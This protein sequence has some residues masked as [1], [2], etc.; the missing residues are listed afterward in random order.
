MEQQSESGGESEQTLKKIEIG[1]DEA[2][3][4][5]VMGSMFV[6]G[7]LGFDRLA[8]IGV[9]DS[10]KLNSARRSHLARIIEQQTTAYVA[11]ISASQIDEERRRGRSMNDITLD[12]ASDVVC[13]FIRIT[14]LPLR[15]FVDAA[16]VKPAR[17][18]ER[19]R[20]CCSLRCESAPEIISEWKADEKYPVVS[21]AS[22]IAK[23]HRDRCMHQISARLGCD[24]GSGYP[25]DPR[26]IAF[27]RGV[28]RGRTE[29]PDSVRPFVRT[30]WRTIHKIRRRAR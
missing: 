15:V 17:F 4:G 13:F 29:I 23:V 22:I 19:L 24:V 21:A 7:V 9:K 16:D 27:L 28:M 30:S 12:L 11:E 14:A 3:R 6:A 2:G 26:T 8:N 1:V 10:K 5:S 18:A 20:D 25:S